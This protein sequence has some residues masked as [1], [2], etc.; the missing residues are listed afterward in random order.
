MSGSPFAGL[1]GSR[2]RIS[3]RNLI[4]NGNAVSQPI[5]KVVCDAAYEGTDR[6]IELCLVSSDLRA[7][8][9]IPTQDIENNLFVARR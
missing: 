6:R 4:S 3:T 9:L 5:R 1:F 7:I 2:C 8:K